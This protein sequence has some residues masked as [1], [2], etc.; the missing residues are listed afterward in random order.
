MNTIFRS[1]VT[2]LYCFLTFYSLF[3]IDYLILSV[4]NCFSFILF[5]TVYELNIC[6]YLYSYLQPTYNCTQLHTH[7]HTFLQI[8]HRTH[9][10]TTV[11]P[12]QRQ[13]G[14]ADIWTQRGW[15]LCFVFVLFYFIFWF[16]LLPAT[17]LTAL[18]ES[19]PQESEGI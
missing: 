6:I 13:N 9:A 5:S 4:F 19:T 14:M 12:T 16:I 15:C 11:Q 18:R 10:K 2:I 8:Q 7:I 1:F 3:I 17:K